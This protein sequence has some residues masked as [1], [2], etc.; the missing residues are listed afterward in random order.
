MPQEWTNRSGTITLGGTSQTLAAADSTRR[1]LTIQNLSTG[2][3]WI[4][5]LGGAAA[6]DTVGSNRLPPGAS[7]TITSPLALAIIGAT[8][9]QKF[10]AAEI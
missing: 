3:L 10:T 1:H 2:D 7:A 8:T 9:G 6:I 5:E 4:N